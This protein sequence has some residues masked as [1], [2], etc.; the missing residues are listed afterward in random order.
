MESR[1]E[2]ERAEV[3]MPLR[4]WSPRLEVDGAAIPYNASIREYNRGRAGYIAKALE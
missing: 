2:M 1:E 3:R 4:T